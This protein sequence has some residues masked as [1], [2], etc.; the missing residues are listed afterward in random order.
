MSRS[1]LVLPA[2]INDDTVLPPLHDATPPLPFLSTLYVYE[3]CSCTPAEQPAQDK[4]ATKKNCGYKT[5]YFHFP[6]SLFAIFAPAGGL[7]PSSRRRRR[8]L[9]YAPQ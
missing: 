9:S 7:F 1:K 5:P 4:T 3:F 6:V 2:H 8:T